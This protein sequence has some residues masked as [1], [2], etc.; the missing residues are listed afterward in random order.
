MGLDLAADRWPKYFAASSPCSLRR[1][2][3]PKPWSLLPSHSSPDM[4]QTQGCGYCLAVLSFLLGHPQ[5]Q[6]V[7]DGI[8]SCAQSYAIVLCMQHVTTPRTKI[9]GYW[10]SLW[11]SQRLNLSA[12]GWFRSKCCIHSRLT[13]TILQV[14]AFQPKRAF[15][16]AATS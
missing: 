14:H 13:F 16:P 11:A 15:Q 1:C 5:A 7:N 2:L 6:A 4:M 9:G 12:I 10:A 3:I 8:A